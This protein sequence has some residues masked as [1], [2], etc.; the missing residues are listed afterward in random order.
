MEA[1]CGWVLTMTNLVVHIT[2]RL[3]LPVSVSAVILCAIILS[4]S[5]VHMPLVAS[6]ASTPQILIS[7]SSANLSVGETFTMTINLTD[8]PN[9]FCYQVVFKYSG[10]ILNL[11]N[12][13]FPDDFVLSGQNHIS[14]WSNETEAAGDVVDHLNYTKAG[15]TLYSGASVS[16][17]NGVLCAA[18]F[19]AVKDGQATIKIATKND[20]AHDDGG[21]TWYTYIEDP[22]ET[23]FEFGINTGTIVVVPEFTPI[24]L[25]M[26]LVIIGTVLLIARKKRA[27]LQERRTGY[28]DHAT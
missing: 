16:V 10:T 1:S 24:V 28:T 9:L 4:G 23:E 6:A 22:T 21:F 7:P 26:T 20:T 5:S 14:L 25:V 2:R 3:I 17:S 13:W 18:N 19:T 8:F 11:T 27:L 15:S 12:L